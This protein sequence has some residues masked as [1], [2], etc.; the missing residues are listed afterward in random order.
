MI[1]STLNYFNLNTTLSKLVLVIS[2]DLKSYFFM[3]SSSEYILKHIPGQVLP[4]LPA[5][6]FACDFV[7]LFST[8]K[9]IFFTKSYSISLSIPQSITTFTRLI[10]SEVS[11]ILVANIIF[12][13]DL[14]FGSEKIKFYSLAESLPCNGNAI[15]SFL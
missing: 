9:L 15:Y 5:L 1:S 12:L 2:G 6:Y 3:K 7:I 10:V 8:M 11:A 4:A 14:C 13:R